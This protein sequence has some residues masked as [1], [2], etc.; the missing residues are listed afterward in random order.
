VLVASNVGGAGQAP[1]RFAEDDARRMADVLRELGHYAD[2]DVRVLLHPGAAD[3]TSA[4][5]ELA[6]KV[7]AGA[8][9]G[10]PSEVVFYYSGHARAN[11]VSIGGDEIP[12]ATLRERLSALP[13]SLTIV[14]LD[15][16][17]SGAFTRVKGAERAAD[18][19]YN[20]VSRLTQRGLAVMASSSSQEL[21]QESDELKGSYFTHHLVTALR[22]A[23][24][25]DGDGRVSLDEAYRYAYRQTLT[26][27]ALTQV[28]EQHVTLE[29]DLTGHDDVPVTY[30][31]EARA[32]LELPGA[33]EGRVLVQRKPSGAVVAELQ[34]VA[35]NPIRL[36]LVAGSYDAVVGRPAGI[37]QCRLSL[38]DD[39]VTPLDTSGCPAV[40]P[41]RTAAKGEEDAAP[42]REIDRWEVEGAAGL[43]WKQTDGYTQ[44][45]EQFGY[46]KQGLDLPGG[47]FTLGVS[48][49]I[50]PH[51]AGVFQL[52]TLA[53]SSYQRQI[54][55][56][57]DTA[58]SNAYGG[59][60]YLR[61]H[62]D[63]LGRWLGVY[64][65]AGV[66]MTLGVTTYQTE[67]SGVPPSTSSVYAG[68]L[69]S[70]AAGATFRFR[71]LATVFVQ[72]GYDRA[73]AITNLIGDTH[74]S[75]GPSVVLGLRL[76][77]GGQP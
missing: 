62:T 9:A 33:L 69:L 4:L 2:A 57:T 5:D 14:V 40:V 3:V 49:E 18:F 17:Q 77:F 30:P 51:V 21:S 31:A 6:A 29:T 12:L 59:A 50:V 56:S 11:A 44:T 76:R 53:G 41:D 13:A 26:S 22:G 39:Q 64:A 67:E 28:G 70:G 8:A 55:G 7:K 25:A 71:R 35:G 61:A 60:L 32:Q 74:D 43:I 68:Y 19:T 42:T 36:A 45:L 15:A 48:R 73:P 46:A 63:V 72:G 52:A 10:E 66:G 34:K 65:Q 27:T 1:L 75:G 24:D 38:A 23:G 54:D 37:V 16:C 20:S 47:R 58:S